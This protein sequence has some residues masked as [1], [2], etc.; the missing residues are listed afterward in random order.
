MRSKEN[1]GRDLQQGLYTVQRVHGT[2]T[3][4]WTGIQFFL[5]R[6]RGW[7]APLA[8]SKHAQ[9]IDG[10]ETVLQSSEAC[11]S[12]SGE[13]LTEGFFFPIPGQV[14]RLGKKVAHKV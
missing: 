5:E 2:L 7:L 6:Y 13:F 1:A 12:E 4:E 14:E 8:N 10:A 11:L 3:F 9:I